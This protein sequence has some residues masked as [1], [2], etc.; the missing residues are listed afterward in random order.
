M[1]DTKISGATAVTTPASTDEYPT[2]QGG[3]SKKTTRAQMHTLESGESLTGEDAAG[4]SIVDEASSATNPTL[5]PNKSDLDT[6]VGSAAADQLSLIA[7]G[8]EGL[9][10]T[11]TAGA[12]AG[13]FTDN[14]TISGSTFGALVLE[15]A[16][17]AVDDKATRLIVNAERFKITSLVDAGGANQDLMTATRSSATWG[18]VTW[19]APHILPAGSAAAP[20]VGFTNS[21]LY[22]PV[23]DAPAITAGGVEA[24][25][26]TEASSHVLTAVQANVGLTADSG[27]IQGGGVILSSYNTYTTVGTAGDAATLPATFIVG[28]IVWVINDSATSMD[29]FPASGDTITGN[30]ADAAEAVAGGARAQF[31]AT[32]ANATWTAVSNA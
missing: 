29:V 26:W 9:R 27:S 12:I 11:E 4:P 15:D 31:L 22:E 19:T 2:N 18:T 32:A 10:V 28:T 6:G 30:A 14:L 17:G 8:V 23:A 20:A 7:G 3:A 13:V 16:T 5:I 25:R 21:G 24:Q 1:A